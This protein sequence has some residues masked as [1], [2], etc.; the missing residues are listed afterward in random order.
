MPIPPGT[1]TAQLRSLRPDLEKKHTW[2][3][4]LLDAYQFLDASLTRELAALDKKPVCAPGCAACCS[5][6]VP[7][8]LAESMGIRLFL[9]EVFCPSPFLPGEED[10]NAFR[11][12]CPFIRSG[13][14]AIYAVR[15][16]ACRRYLVFSRQCAP[17]EDPVTARPGDVHDASAW[18]LLRAQQMTLPIYRALGHAAEDSAG[19]DFFKKFSTFIQHIPW[20]RP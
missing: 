16:F 13:N 18:A 11:W 2:L 7:L 20:R 4:V 19:S 15:P 3:T 6:P 12:Q 9:N 10:E 17:K 8:S 1:D 14:C 5:Q